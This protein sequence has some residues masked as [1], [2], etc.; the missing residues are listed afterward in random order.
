MDIQALTKFF[1]WCTILN[2]ALLILWTLVCFCALDW[3]YR[4]H[5]RWFSFPRE[6]FNAIIYLFLGIFKMVFLVFN[7]APFVAL[8]IVG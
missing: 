2:G 7:A 8:L 3:V 1:M 4:I 5:G 6:T